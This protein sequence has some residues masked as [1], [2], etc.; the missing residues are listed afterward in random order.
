MV[1][2]PRRILPM[3][4]VNHIPQYAVAEDVLDEVGSLFTQRIPFC[5]QDWHVEAL[6]EWWDVTVPLELLEQRVSCF[7]LAASLRSAWETGAG[8][9]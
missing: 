3:R 1:P 7:D 5:L 9:L 8:N 6:S 4:S 2:E